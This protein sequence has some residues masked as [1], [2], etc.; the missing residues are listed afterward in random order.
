MELEI[1]GVIV[2]I[3]FRADTVTI[4]AVVQDTKELLIGPSGTMKVMVATRPVEL[5]KDAKGL[6]ALVKVGMGADS[7]D[8][9]KESIRCAI[10]NR[11]A[12]FFT[13][14]LTSP[15]IAPTKISADGLKYQPPVKG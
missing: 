2:R 15:R 13:R 4:A 9:G 8:F 1:D 3:T 5:C 6:M 12:G 7:R 14:S 10:S 11:Q